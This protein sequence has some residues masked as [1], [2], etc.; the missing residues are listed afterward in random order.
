MEKLKDSLDFEIVEQLIIEQQQSEDQNKSNNKNSVKRYDPKYRAL[1][2]AFRQMEDEDHQ[3]NNQSSSSNTSPRKMNYS[4]AQQQQQNQFQENFREND[5]TKNKNATN[6]NKQQHQNHQLQ[7]QQHE[8]PQQQQQ[9]HFQ[10][11]LHPKQRHL[12]NEYQF[13]SYYQQHTNRKSAI[14]NSFDSK[15]E[16]ESR[17][18]SVTRD[19]MHN[20]PQRVSYDTGKLAVTTPTTPTNSNIN[21]NS[22]SNSNMNEENTSTSTNN[23]ITNEKVEQNQNP[24]N[25]QNNQQTTPPTSSSSWSASEQQHTNRKSAILNSF[26]SKNEIASRTGSSPKR[27]VSNDDNNKQEMTEE[28]TEELSPDTDAGGGDDRDDDD[29]PPPSPI[30]EPEIMDKDNDPPLLLVEEPVNPPPSTTPQPKPSSNTELQDLNTSSSSPLESVSNAAPA[31]RNTNSKHEPEVV[32][33][34]ITDPIPTPSTSCDIKPSV[35]RLDKLKDPQPN[36]Y[37]TELDF[38]F[39]VESKKKLASKERRAKAVALMEA[40]ADAILDPVDKTTHQLLQ[41]QHSESETPVSN[42]LTFY[43]LE[44]F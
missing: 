28:V 38:E 5:F 39:R 37:N 19:G 3:H 9:Q 24:E 20:M 22:N 29:P 4:S 11:P 42:F 15:S 32:N 30:P 33:K 27:C 16:F 8:Q 12:S 31:I 44:F 41:R 34:Q 1:T 10:Y 6:Q 7:Q 25:Q 23:T 26:D 40:H 43:V 35:E 14:L 17:T 18:G 36:S 2:E 13:K 21:P